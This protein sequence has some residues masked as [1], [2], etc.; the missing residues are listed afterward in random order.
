MGRQKEP[1][2]WQI[3]TWLEGKTDFFE[4]QEQ[5]TEWLFQAYGI[6]NI[7]LGA[8]LAKFNSLVKKVKLTPANAQSA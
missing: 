2:E 6:T 8:D 3:K 7:R 4:N 5:I 1:L